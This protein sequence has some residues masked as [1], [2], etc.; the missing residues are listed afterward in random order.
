MASRAV[1][2]RAATITPIRRRYLRRSVT[3]PGRVAASGAGRWVR[4][5]DLRVCLE[6]GLR[7][8]G[9]RAAR[10]AHLEL[11]GDAHGHV[12]LP[13]LRDLAVHAA[14]GDDLVADLQV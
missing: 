12:F 7:D 3:C 1:P 11:R 8:P 14:C 10:H 9:D 13:Q 5:V 6:L 2:T 4:A